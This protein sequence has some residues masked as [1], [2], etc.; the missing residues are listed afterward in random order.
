MVLGGGPAGLTAALLL[1]RIGHSVTVCERGPEL[2]GLWACK[3]D[4]NGRYLSENSC[5]V[6]QDSYRAAPAL[7]AMIGTRWQDHFIPRHDLA[8]DWLR[9]FILD[10]SARDLGQFAAALAVWAAGARSY[11]TVSVEDWLADGR[12]SDRCRAWMRATALGGITGTLRMTM[13]ELFHRLSANLGS[14]V[15]G[16]GGTLYWNAQPPNGPGGFVSV[17]RAALQRAGVHIQTNRQAIAVMSGP[18]G[19]RIEFDGS[20]AIEADAVFLAMPPRALATLFDASD[21]DLAAAFGHDL[22]GMRTV[23]GDSLYEHLGI[24]WSF[25]RALPLPL[26]LGGHNVRSGWHPILVQFDQY[27]PSLP[28]N[29]VMSVVGSISLE[30]DFIHPRLGTLAREHPYPELARILWEDE[31][32]VDPTLPEPVKIEVYGLSDATQIVRHGPMPIR[33]AG[34]DVFLA[35]SLNGA[36]PYFTASLEAAIQA[37]AAAA[38]VYDPR[39]ERLPS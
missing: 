2:G 19:T 9:P 38:A 39:V 7:F 29:Q 17:W 8:H 12:L 30:T 25:D 16:R 11:D 26:P 36:A 13:A 32:R 23:L 22:T 10:S 37:G 5:K 1:A 3:L 18:K 20:A 4:E 33:A 24:T 27:R 14:I 31:R 6:Y 35:T 15:T 34:R 21:P 28:P